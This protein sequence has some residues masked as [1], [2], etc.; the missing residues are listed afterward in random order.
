MIIRGDR[1]RPRPPRRP[2]DSFRDATPGCTSYARYEGEQRQPATPPAIR[3]DIRQKK[4]AME[5]PLAES[6]PPRV[7]LMAAWGRYPIVVA[8]QLKRQG[9]HVSCLAIKDHADPVLREICDDFAWQGLAQLGRAIRFFHRRGVRQATMAGKF[10]KVVLYQ[11]WVWLRHLPDWKAIKTFYPHFYSGSRD[12]RDDTLLGAIV[13][14]FAAEGVEFGPATNFAPELLV[15]AGPINGQLTAA[16]ERD[17]AFGW[18]LAK[19]MGR[20]DVGQSVC[21]K[22]QSVI[23]IEAIEGTDLCIERAGQL[24]ASG[25]FTIVKVAKPEQDMRFDVPTIGIGT[26][27]TMVAARAKVLAVE[28]GQT[29]ILDEAEFVDFA[30]RNR[31]TVVALDSPAALEAAA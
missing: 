30:R 14:A 8:Q 10:H 16:E 20:L 21:V 6:E 28:A 18:R 24:C 5:Y 15:K 13:D 7:G 4:W 31:L 9:F 27:E 17:V 23:A 25:G 26:L 1:K 2:R 12:R 11:P 22:R 19:E 29:I 3:R